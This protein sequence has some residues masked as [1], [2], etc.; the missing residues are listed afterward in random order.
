MEKE[1]L[2][3]WADIEQYLIC[4]S[5]DGSPE[6]ELVPW[7]AESDLDGFYGLQG[8][9]L[10]PLAAVENFV[11]QVQELRKYNNENHGVNNQ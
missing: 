3:A 9:G 5:Y 7:S 10:T 6:S 4:L 11:H 2:A 8:G 1:I